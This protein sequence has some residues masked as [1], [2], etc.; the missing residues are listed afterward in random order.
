LSLAASQDGFT[1]K[2]DA[3][4]RYPTD[5][6]TLT[7]TPTEIAERPVE[8]NDVDVYIDTSYANLGS[9]KLT[10]A[11]A[12]NFDCGTKFKEVFVHNSA[13]AEFYDV[14]E[15]PYE[16]KYSFETVHNAQSRTLVAAI[17]TNPTKWIRWAAVGN[18]LGNVS[19]VD[20]YEKIWIDMAFK[21]D[22]PEPMENEG[23][24]YGYKFNGTTYPDSAGLGSHMRITVTN[25]IATL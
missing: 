9:T 2:S 20:Y 11:L 7:A 19:S 6:T 18:L 24:V 16:A 14:I 3:I 5:N 17:T 1:V 15:I 23:E 4:S 8:R 21:F 22:A 25:G 13:A 10:E 12:E